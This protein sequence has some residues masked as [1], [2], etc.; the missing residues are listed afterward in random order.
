MVRCLQ[1]LDVVREFFAPN[2]EHLFAFGQNLT[3][4]VQVK[5]SGQPGQRI[6]L[7]HAESLDE[8][9]N[10]YTGN[11]SFAKATD[12]Y[13]LNGEPQTLRPHFTYHGFRYVCLE[14]LQ[15]GQDIS[16]SA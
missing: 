3:G 9:G 4:W 7:R 5:I 15:E 6:A 13:I 1:R 10:F 2:G 11:L 12:V 8:N 14:G 16:L